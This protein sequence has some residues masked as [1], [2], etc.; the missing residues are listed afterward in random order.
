VRID[1][2][3]PG[4]FVEV[5]DVNLLGVFALP[6][7][8]TPES[9]DAVIAEA[10]GHPIGAT[11]LRELANAGKSVL[12]VTDDVARPTPAWKVIPYVLEELH[13]AGIADENIEFMMALGTHRP[14]TEA[15]M[16]AKVGDAAFE[17]YKVHNHEWDN[18]EALEYVGDTDQS[19]PVWINRKV[20]EADIVVGIGRIMP[21]EVCGFTG[22]GK[23]LIPGCCGEVTN[24]EMHW[25][26]VDV[27]GSEVIGLRDNPIR[28]SIDALARK[29]GLD[30][31]V[32]II[33]DSC[34]RIIDCVAGDLVDAHRVGCEKARALHEVHIAERA[35]IVIVDGYP[36]D[37]EFWQV[38]K[39]IDTAG[40]VVKEGGIVICV[41]PCHEGFSVTHSDVLLEF[42]YRKKSEIKEL[43]ESGVI[44]HKV[45]GVHM[46]QVAEVAIERAKVYLVTDG[47]CARDIEKVGLRRAP[48]P[49][50][51]LQEAFRELGQDASV[52]VLRSAAEMLPV[53]GKGQGRN[54]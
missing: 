33:M 37:I 1:F 28:A 4:A 2:P 24:S 7:P 9:E 6:R 20:R 38:N 21:I 29:A 34:A 14:M 18:P 17:R 25:T 54:Q 22:G 42:G 39:A 16:R 49:Q 40:L 51:A 27:A 23:I 47:I 48:T 44:H 31:I 41:S 35:D 32:N 52:V 53:I 8:Q 26:R 13:R 5:P 43:V 19:V 45:V 50:E 15:E 3:Y 36:F 12:I 11:P 46:I 30:F 10:L